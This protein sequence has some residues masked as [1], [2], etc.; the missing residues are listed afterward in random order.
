[1]INTFSQKVIRAAAGTGK[2]YRLSLEFITLLLKHADRGMSFRDILVITFTKKAT[3]EI[4]ERIFQHLTDIFKNTKEGPTVV[5]NLGIVL[6]R[7][8]SF[9]DM[10][11]LKKIYKEMRINKHFVQIMTIDGFIN[12]VFKTIIAPFIGLTQYSISTQDN[13]KIVQELYSHILETPEFLTRLE[14]FFKR[15]ALKTIE[16]YTK[17]IQSLLDNRW[18]FYLVDNAGSEKRYPD[19]E[20]LAD[21]RLFDEFSTIISR[22][23]GRF[24]NYLD[25]TDRDLPPGDILISQML[26]ICVRPGDNV[27]KN[28]ICAHLEKLFN[29]KKFVVDHHK[30]LLA[31]QRFWSKKK[32]L[33]KNADKPF[34]EE[35]TVDLE[36]AYERLA[37]WLY[38]TQLLPEEQEIRQM[39]DIVYQ[40]YEKIVFREKIFSYSDITFYTFKYLYDP[41]L[42]LIDNNYVTNAFYEILST[43]I[44][45]ILIDEFQD[46]SIIQ[47][48]ILLPI[49]MEIISGEGIKEF[50]GVIV[51][52][53]EKQSIYGWRGGER[54]LLLRMPNLLTKPELLRLDTCYRSN[55]TLLSFINNMFSH[56][57]FHR[58]LENR[59][60]QWPYEYVKGT[61]KTDEGFIRIVFSQYG[62]KEGVPERTDCLRAFIADILEKQ[63]ILSMKNT[64]I[65][66]R[67]NKRLEECAQ[68]LDE[69]GVNYVLESSSSIFQHRAIRP[70]LMLLKFFA[71]QDITSLLKFLRSDLV[72]LSAQKLTQILSALGDH[73]FSL[74]K[75]IFI[76]EIKTIYDN[77]LPESAKDSELLVLVQKIIE[78]Y[79]V[80]GVFNQEN[81]IKNIHFF[82]EVVADFLQSNRDYPASTP[83]F[84]L[85]CREHE[86]DENL[87]QKGLQEVDAVKLLTFHKSKG[88]EF[89]NVFLLWDLSG[90]SGSDRG[91]LSPYFSYTG[92]FD[93]ENFSL[94]F[95]FDH[96]IEYSSQRHFS[97]NKKIRQAIEEM[98]NFYVAA[99]RARTNLFIY[100]LYQKSSGLQALFKEREESDRSDYI[101]AQVALELATSQYSKVADSE[102]KLVFES[103]RLTPQK[104]EESKTEPDNYTY[105]RDFMDLD[106]KKFLETDM[107][108]LELEKHLDFKTVYLRN[109]NTDRGNVAHYY[110]S[111]IH[112]DEPDQRQHALERTIAF[113]GTLFTRAEIDY[114]V[115]KVNRFIETNTF[116]FAKTWPGVFTELELYGR[117]GRVRLDR[118]LVNKEKKEILILDF[119]TGEIYEKTQIGEYIETVKDLP[120]VQKDQYVVKGKFLE[121]KVG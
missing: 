6:G 21:D 24:Q 44:R 10:E 14:K 117:F 16:H 17:F 4:R 83:G 100:F 50:G 90:G 23:L 119:K 101:A 70:I 91:K 87:Q 105:I 53:D 39:A 113:Y 82:L 11:H 97:Q 2:T 36:T 49:I 30:D 20:Q 37:D 18:L 52:G 74:K 43:N 35:L 120:S 89:D 47:Y 68:I 7:S 1:M 93:I 85:F 95:N 13:E 67:Y 15:S 114:I 88:L 109:R 28:N 103:G 59:G 60:I 92:G 66:A 48:K 104:A 116:L 27:H 98:N 56:D 57:L 115:E 102:I 55:E 99:T 75:Y 51:V 58:E 26:D 42:S 46:T 77:F 62:S 121:I 72:L 31:N 80:P 71:W 78:T 81:D 106:E 69:S 96:I 112:Y 118:M 9:S 111:F 73:Q 5:E 54:D 79:N 84:L 61:G 110:L 22:I 86:N 65:L 94:T 32:L 64:A 34:E 63:K 29:D 40:K 41:E 25:Q 8:L 107:K 38:V 12:S 108:R 3:A 76:P 45:F 19:A 33:R